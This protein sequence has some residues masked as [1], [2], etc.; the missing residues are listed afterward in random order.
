MDSPKNNS[1][2]KLRKEITLGTILQIVVLAGM[3][4]ASWSNLQSRLAIIRYEINRLAS[5]NQ[6]MYQQIELLG[7][8]CQNHK[9]RIKF[10]EKTTSVLNDTTTK[11]NAML[12]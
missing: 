10:L 12:R 11:Q 4:I 7:Y 3:L 9:Y 6:K 5:E 2:W 1:S 8:E